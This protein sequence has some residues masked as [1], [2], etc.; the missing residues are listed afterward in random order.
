MGTGR[1]CVAAARSSSAAAGRGDL[2][3]G[4]TGSQGHLDIDVDATAATGAKSRRTPTTNFWRARRDKR[5]NQTFMSSAFLFISTRSPGAGDAQYAPLIIDRSSS[6]VTGSKSGHA[7]AHHHPTAQPARAAR[8]QRFRIADPTATCASR[9]SSTSA[10][11][12]VNTT[13]SR[14]E[15]DYE[16]T[17]HG[18][19]AATLVFHTFWDMDLYFTPA[20][21]T[22]MSSVGSRPLL[23]VPTHPGHPLQGGSLADGGSTTPMTAY[24]AASSLHAERRTRVFDGR[25][26][27]SSRVGRAR[28]ADGVAQQ[29]RVTSHQHG[30]VR[31][32]KRR[33]RCSAWS[34]ASRSRRTRRTRSAC[35]AT[36]ART[37]CRAT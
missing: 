21:S 14:L 27:G 29:R 19:A 30:R 35:A 25:Q 10:V 2:D 7:D 15:Q 32:I 16:I 37:P 26:H 12:M 3:N 11:V 22:T 36:T 24:Y 33:T 20:C 18:T 1:V 4:I 31:R 8:P 34:G 13:S 17:K 9:P 6:W 28:H 5:E 23:R